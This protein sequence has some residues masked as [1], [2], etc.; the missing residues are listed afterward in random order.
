MSRITSEIA[1]SEATEGD[2]GTPD[3]VPLP[4]ADENQVPP[5]EAEDPKAVEKRRIAAE[6]EAGVC[7]S[8]G[9]NIFSSCPRYIEGTL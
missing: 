3:E 9:S 5:Q 7:I 6:K 1:D 2:I 4:T 8:K